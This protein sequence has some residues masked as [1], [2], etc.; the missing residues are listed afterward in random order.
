NNNNN[1][2]TKPK[3]NNIKSILKSN[4]LKEYTEICY[5]N[6]HADSIH[7][8]IPFGS[9]PYSNTFLTG[10]KDCTLKM[11]SMNS[12]GEF[13]MFNDINTN[14]NNNNI[15]NIRNTYE[16]WITCMDKIEFTDDDDKEKKNN[17]TITGYPSI[18]YGTR[19]G[20]IK[21]F[22]L[23]NRFDGEYKY[24]DDDNNNNNN[25]NNI[26]YKKRNINRI[27]CLLKSTQ[28]SGIIYAG[29]AGGFSTFKIS[30][31]NIHDKNIKIEYESTMELHPYKWIYQM[32]YYDENRDFMFVVCGNMIFIMKY[33]QSKSLWE[34]KCLLQVNR[35]DHI[36]NTMKKFISAI[37]HDK[38]YVYSAC[39]DGIIKKVDIET[40]VEWIKRGH[41]TTELNSRIWD[42]K[43]LEKNVLI[44]CGN[45][46]L[47][48]IWD[49]RVNNSVA[50]IPP[51]D[52]IHNKKHGRVS[53]LCILDSKTFI[54]SREPI[55][56]YRYREN[57]LVYYDIRNISSKNKKTK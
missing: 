41:D 10:S 34:K 15:N 8:I 38:N 39:F 21:I 14:N 57:Q 32:Q 54:S 24:V 44:S 3:D 45:D 28:E 55:D 16:T 43:F 49:E 36:D 48:L 53:N 50:S 27:N 40:S 13:N 20:R 19:D 6:A 47:I 30:K 37:V 2:N 9:S 25:N 22:N 23:N 51:V 33:N 7:C 35:Y 5:D 52:K 26:I 18:M 1:N 42:I 12:S 46:G 29:H 56:K 17:L 11:W 4:N 31:Q